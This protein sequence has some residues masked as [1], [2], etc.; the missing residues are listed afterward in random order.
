MKTIAI[1]NLGCKVNSYELDVLTE[2]LRKSGHIIVPFDEKADIYV[3]NTCTVTNIADRKSRQML[4][5]AKR[6]NPEALIVAL[7]CYVESA[8]LQT[9]KD[10]CIDIALGNKDKEKLLTIIADYE[11]AKRSRTVA[12][13][14]YKESLQGKSVP[15][16]EEEKPFHLGLHE[17]PTRTRS[18]IKIQ[19]GCNM[20][21]TYCIIPYVRG[22]I[23]SRPE[24]DILREIATLA[25][26]GCR[27]VVLTGIHIASYGLDRGESELIRLLG[28]IQEIPEIKR[29]RIS[30]MEPKIITEECAR[31]FASIPK[32][33]PHFHL[34]LQ[35]G[36]DATLKRMNRHYDINCFEK[37]VDLLRTVYENPA[38]TTDV[39]VGFPGETE[40][41]FEISRREIEKIHFYETHVFKYSKRRGTLAAAY[42]DQIP[43]K[44]KHERSSILIQLSR[45]NAEEY[46]R[47]FLDRTVE[48]LLEEEEKVDGKRVLSGLTDRYVRVG[49]ETAPLSQEEGERLRPGELVKMKTEGFLAG[50]IIA[51]K[52]LLL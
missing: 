46:R 34:S 43:E 25:S 5:K 1:H 9:Q 42:E 32:L 38:I 3:V 47:L 22:R 52:P 7:G 24:E 48:V 33:C 21:C 36:C 50:E 28:R 41:E 49:A 15:V 37:S 11:K 23:N 6:E 51:G 45:K 4:H 16:A 2:N 20:F 44:I 27:E 14:S 29:I 12:P 30:S 18:Y 8:N 13:D 39:I 10:D 17:L 35:S 40:E 31:A 26:K 19:D